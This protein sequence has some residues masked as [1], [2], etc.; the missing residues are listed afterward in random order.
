MAEICEEPRQ[1]DPLNAR[2]QPLLLL[3]YVLNLAGRAHRARTLRA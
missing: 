1:A 2:R 3:D